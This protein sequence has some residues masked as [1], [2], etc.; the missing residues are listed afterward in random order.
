MFNPNDWEDY[1]P[2]DLE[3]I[4]SALG[5]D[6]IPVFKQWYEEYYWE[7][8]RSVEDALN[9]FQEYLYGIYDSKEAFAEELVD[10]QTD[11]S[12]PK[13]FIDYFD[14]EAYAR[15]LFLDSFT[16]MELPNGMI[17]VFNYR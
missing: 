4:D 14:Y 11:G 5:R 2:E 6:L 15:D 13:M 1:S 3:R 7:E 16:D 10:E 8:K 12:I 17:A 9:K